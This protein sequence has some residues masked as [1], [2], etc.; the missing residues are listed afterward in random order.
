MPRL[1]AIPP[2]AAT[3]CDRVGNNFV[4]HAVFKPC[5]DRPIAA[6]RPAPPAPTT[7]ASYSWSMIVYAAVPDQNRA[8]RGRG[9]SEGGRVS[10]SFFRPSSR[11][12]TSR[13]APPRSATS[14]ACALSLRTFAYLGHPRSPRQ[15]SS[16]IPR[17]LASRAPPIRV[18]DRRET[19]I[20]GGTARRRSRARN[21]ERATRH[22]D[23]A[24]LPVARACHIGHENKQRAERGGAHAPGA[25]AADEAA[26]EVCRPHAACRVHAGAAHLAAAPRIF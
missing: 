21:C 10:S 8:R 25:F 14:S 12:P 24:D 9:G 13:D 18:D 16:E 17:A 5:S 4:M 1:A 3:V 15:V 2:C 6:R 19:T 11:M 26:P 23:R 20:A 22:L 7:T